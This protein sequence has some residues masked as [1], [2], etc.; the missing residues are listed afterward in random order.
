MTKTDVLSWAQTAACVLP[1]LIVGISS[2]TSPTTSYL[3]KFIQ[4]RNSII[5][6]DVI[7]IQ[8]Y[9]T[10]NLLMILLIS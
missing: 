9:D 10:F 3:L 5:W 4:L 1:I 8:S 2:Q 6:I 7:S